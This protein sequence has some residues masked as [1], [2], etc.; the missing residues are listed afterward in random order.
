MKQLKSTGR[1][2]LLT[3][4]I[5]SFM[6]CQNKT[7]N[8][9]TVSNSKQSVNEQI[10]GYP[11]EIKTLKLEKQFD[12][13]KWSLYLYNCLDTPFIARDETTIKLDRPMSAYELRYDTVINKNGN[14]IITF[15]YYLKNGESLRDSIS[16]SWS[17]FLPNTITSSI[18]NVEKCAVLIH[19][20]DDSES[21]ECLNDMPP[22][23]KNITEY[24]KSK[25]KKDYMDYVRLYRKLY[26]PLDNHTV[27]FINKN[28][29]TLNKWFIQEAEKRGVLD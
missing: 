22:N 24:Y 25:Y 13:T 10:D 19:P 4:M 17:M 6:S 3:S 11:Q 7:P 29:S 14:Y 12:D 18:K 2:I 21:K 15:E 8:T 16:D 9:T 20:N 5:P 28:R 27:D 1:L 26:D 23:A